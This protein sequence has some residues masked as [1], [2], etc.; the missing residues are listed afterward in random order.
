[1]N[2]IYIILWAD[3]TTCIRQYHQPSA[4]EEKL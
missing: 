4:Q 1:M 2:F 3:V